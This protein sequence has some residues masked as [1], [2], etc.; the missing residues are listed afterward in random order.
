ME[1]KFYTLVIILFLLSVIVSLSSCECG[2][3]ENVNANGKI[4][5]QNIYKFE[6]THEI[7]VFTIEHDNAEYVVFTRCGYNGG[8]Y[9]IE[10]SK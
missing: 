4:K 3:N 7:H 2:E 5:C 8:I 9:A 10:K 6:T 1:D